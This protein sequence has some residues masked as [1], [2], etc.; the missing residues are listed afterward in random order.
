MIY[1]ISSGFKNSLPRDL[2]RTLRAAYL[3]YTIGIVNEVCS[4]NEKAWI[5]NL[6]DAETVVIARVMNG[7]LVELAHYKNAGKSR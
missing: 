3:D 6:E 1:S 7:E 2:L 4:N 5:I